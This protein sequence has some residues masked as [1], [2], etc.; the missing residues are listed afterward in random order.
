MK[1]LQYLFMS[2]AA[3]LFATPAF[4]QGAAAPSPGAQWVPLAAG[5]GMALA[6]GLGM[7]LAAGLC[8]LGQ[9]KA[10]ASATEA[11]AR[12]PGARPGIFIFLI[13]GLAFIES[14]ALFTFVIIFLK[15]Q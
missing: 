4:A 5:L 9:G 15:V 13:L 1:K 6:A 14:L 11:L 10:T 7:A 2:L 3:L 8:G 12:N